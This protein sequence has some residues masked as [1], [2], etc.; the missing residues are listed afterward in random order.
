MT[1][2]VVNNNAGE[3]YTLLFYFLLSLLFRLLHISCLRKGKQNKNKPLKTNKQTKSNKKNCQCCLLWSREK[4]QRKH[5]MKKL[6]KTHTS[7]TTSLLALIVHPS[8]F[9]C[10]VTCSNWKWRNP[11]YVLLLI[12]YILDLGHSHH[13]VSFLWWLGAYVTLTNIPFSAG[14]YFQRR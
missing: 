5:E 8:I 7:I 11:D 13:S 10:R 14:L 4:I 6:L 2:S 12:F 3:C 1:F 9:H